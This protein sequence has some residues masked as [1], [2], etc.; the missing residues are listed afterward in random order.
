MTPRPRSP[1]RR[2]RSASRATQ[3]GQQPCREGTRARGV[4]LPEVP[5]LTPAPPPHAA[6]LLS[7][8]TKHEESERFHLQTAEAPLI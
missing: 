4:A 6:T 3:R 1:S 8:I 2:T 5:Q 7:R